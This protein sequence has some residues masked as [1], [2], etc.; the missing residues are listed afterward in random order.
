SGRTIYIDGL[1][2]VAGATAQ[3]FSAGGNILNLESSNSNITLNN[4]N[5][6]ELQAWQLNANALS[7]SLRY[8]AT[9]VASGYIYAIGGHNGTS[10]VT[11]VY[12]AKLNADGS[13]ASW[14]S[15]NTLPNGRYLAGAVVAN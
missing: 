14:N 6:G 1:T 15:T 7:A 4:T 2:L 5:S 13:T 12:Y 10:A 9:A 11:S 8:A 3:T